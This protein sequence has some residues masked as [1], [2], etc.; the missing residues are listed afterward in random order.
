MMRNRKRFGVIPA[1]ILLVS[2]LTAACGSQAGAPDS[3]AAPLDT[4]IKD[5]QDRGTLRVGL[6][7]EAPWAV[8]DTETGEWM[9]V[10]VDI[11]QYVADQLEVELEPVETDWSRVVPDVVADKIDVAAPGLYATPARA[12]VVWFSKPYAELGQIFVVSA[13]REDLQTVEDLNS[14]EITVAVNPGSITVDVANLFLPN[15]E[16]RT[17]TTMG[18]SAFMAE[19]LAGRADTFGLD[20]IKGPAFREAYPEIKTIPD[21]WRNAVFKSPIAFA[22]QNNQP[23]FLQ[24]LN[25]CLDNLELSGELDRIY[26]EWLMSDY[27]LQ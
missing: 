8:K 26:Q 17:V 11:M 18:T 9:G 24:F 19:V 22:I 21:D 15:A 4:R 12:Q 23:D 16:Q 25:V 27:M 6:I 1:L 5:I 20:N 7:I 13:E 10:S 2:L 3:A 14:S